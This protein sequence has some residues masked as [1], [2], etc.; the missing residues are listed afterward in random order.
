MFQKI[1]SFKSVVK[2]WIWLRISAVFIPIWE[3]LKSL[4]S[5]NTKRELIKMYEALPKPQIDIY[6]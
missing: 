1:R 5:S 6:N 3:I 4:T 2:F